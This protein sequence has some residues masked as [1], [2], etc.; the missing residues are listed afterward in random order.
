MVSHQMTISHC[1]SFAPLYGALITAAKQ[2]SATMQRPQWAA[3]SKLSSTPP[4]ECWRPLSVDV[5]S[6]DDNQSLQKLCSTVQR[7]NRRCQAKINNY[8]ETTMSSQVQTVIH[9]SQRVFETTFHWCFHIGWHSVIAKALL[10]CMA[11]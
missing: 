5:F 6:S 1:K 2:K 10:R 9:A 4:G 11:R 8:A 3:K 7:V